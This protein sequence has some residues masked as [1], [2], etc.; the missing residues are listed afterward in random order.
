MCVEII[1]VGVK[2]INHCKVT[3]NMSYLKNMNA[4]DFLHLLM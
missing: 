3:D 1:G 2:I 4:T